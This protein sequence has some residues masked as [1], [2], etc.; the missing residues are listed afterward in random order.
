MQ[1]IGENISADKLREK[2]HG[3]VKEFDSAVRSMTSSEFKSLK[4]KA[5]LNLFLSSLNSS[6][7]SKDQEVGKDSIVDSLGNASKYVEA[8]KVLMSNN[9]PPAVQKK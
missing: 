7:V 2:L 6:I 5:A 1:I 8:Y 9:N 3:M 4:S